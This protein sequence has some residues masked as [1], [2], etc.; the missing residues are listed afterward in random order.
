MV[1]KSF[2][3]SAR[4]AAAKDELPFWKRKSLARMSKQE[5][6]SLCD[7]CGLCCTNKLEY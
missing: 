4:R 1:A 7:V 3:R 6:E 2:L 5:W